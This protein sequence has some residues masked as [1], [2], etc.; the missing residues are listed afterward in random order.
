MSLFE[1]STCRLGL[2]DALI[3]RNA[4]KLQLCCFAE[5]YNVSSGIPE[6]VLFDNLALGP[7]FNT[8]VT[9]YELV[10]FLLLW[11]VRRT[12]VCQNPEGC[13]WQPAHQLWDVHSFHT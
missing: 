9:E 13:Y 10:I 7:A 1:I 11:S 8:Q 5:T 12:Q 2:K 6:L 3:N 4:G